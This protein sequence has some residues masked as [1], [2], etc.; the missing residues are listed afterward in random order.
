MPCSE[1]VVILIL[2]L[3][4][5]QARASRQPWVAGIISLTVAAAGGVRYVLRQAP[6]ALQAS[7]EAWA[8]PSSWL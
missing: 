1:V 3:S 6:G 8:Q 2:I 4:L 5:N 7:W